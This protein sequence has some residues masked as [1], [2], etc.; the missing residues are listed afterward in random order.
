M[1]II[2]VITIPIIIATVLSGQRTMMSAWM[3]IVASKNVDL[4]DVIRTAYQVTT[5]LIFPTDMPII[6]FKVE[7]YIISVLYQRIKI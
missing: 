6:F 5:S 3:F 4:D 1:I 7:L 2:V